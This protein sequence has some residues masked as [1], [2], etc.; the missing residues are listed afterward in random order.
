MGLVIKKNKVDQARWMI[1]VKCCKVSKVTVVHRQ[2]V[3]LFRDPIINHLAF[4]RLVVSKKVFF[5]V[6]ACAIGLH[7]IC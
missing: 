2:T 5:E 7:C 1:D 4:M 3:N 6:H